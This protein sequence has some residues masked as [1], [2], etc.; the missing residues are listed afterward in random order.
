M[1]LYARRRGYVGGD[2]GLID[3]DLC[4]VQVPGY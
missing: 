1:Q 2:H 4:W 3:N